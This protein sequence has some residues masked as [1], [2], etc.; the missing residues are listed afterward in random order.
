VEAPALTTGQRTYPLLLVAAV[1]VESATIGAAGHLEFADIQNIQS[2]RYVLPDRFVIGQVVATLV[3]KGHL[4]GRANLDFT[5]IRFFAPGNHFEQSGFTSA[6]GPNDAD[7]GTG[8]HLEAQVINQHTVAERLG[9][10][11]K[12]DHFMAKAV[13][14]GN[15]DFVGFVALLV[16]KVAQFLKACQTGLALG[17]PRLGILA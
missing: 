5:R 4:D 10:V 11:R 12:L 16:F 14:H 3:N 9:H 1:E 2:A 7:D 13:S 6:V 15:K 17:L 8:R